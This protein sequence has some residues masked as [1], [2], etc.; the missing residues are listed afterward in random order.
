[1][2]FREHRGGFKES[3]LTLT[4]IEPTA[5]AIKAHL[6][7]RYEHSNTR[8]FL[9]DPAEVTCE[10]YYDEPDTRMRPP[11]KQTYIIGDSRGVIGLCDKP[12]QQPVDKNELL[13]QEARDAI[14]QL[15]NSADPECPFC[16]GTTEHSGSGHKRSCIVNRLLETP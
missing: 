14:V 1:M 3:L 10:L 9:L 16:G 2:R 15:T 8:F 12:L 13:L 4:H 11:W 7:R 5:K 6:N